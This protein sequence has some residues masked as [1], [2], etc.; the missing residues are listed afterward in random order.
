MRWLPKLISAAI[1]VLAA[2]LLTGVLPLPAWLRLP[3]WLIWVVAAFAGAVL[4]NELL[5][6]PVPFLR[7]SVLRMLFGMRRLLSDWQV[8][9][10][11]EQRVTDHVLKNA[12]QGDLS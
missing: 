1:L 4:I 12:R 11:R 10:G 7:W 6:K 9:D 5:G 2:G 8:G 3:H